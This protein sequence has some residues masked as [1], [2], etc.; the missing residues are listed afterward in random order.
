V[1]C[2]WWLTTTF[3]MCNTR[4]QRRPDFH[5]CSIFMILGEFILQPAL[6]Q[7]LDLLCVIVA[8]NK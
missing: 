2:V 6:E 8:A 3:G 4:C 1:I 5:A 7:Q